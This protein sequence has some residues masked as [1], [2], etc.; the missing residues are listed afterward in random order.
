MFF[1]VCLFT[2]GTNDVQMKSGSPIAMNTVN[3]NI[4]EYKERFLFLEFCL[5]QLYKTTL[6]GLKKYSINHYVHISQRLCLV[7]FLLIFVCLFGLFCEGVSLCSTRW[8]QT[9]C[10]PQRHQVSRKFFQLC[11]WGYRCVLTHRV[12]AGPSGCEKGISKSL[13]I[14]VNFSFTNVIF[15]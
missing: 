15:L 11:F 3:Q 1:S 12:I 5:F 10:G 8:H 14:W 6:D 7:L 2:S 4:K 9:D 13:V